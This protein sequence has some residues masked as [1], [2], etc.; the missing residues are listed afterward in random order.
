MQFESLL[1]PISEAQPCGEDISYLPE[2]MELD[3]MIQGTPETQF[4]EAVKP[5]WKLIHLRC[6]E[7]FQK[8]KHLQVSAVFCVSSLQTGGIPVAAGALELL[9]NLLQK[10]W[11]DLY[12]KLD[13]EDDNDPLERMNILSSLS[14]PIGTFGDYFQ[15]IERLREA[16]LTNSPVLGRIGYGT[17]MPESGAHGGEAPDQTQIDAAFRDTPQ[18]DIVSTHEALELGHL[19]LPAWLPKILEDAFEP[20]TATQF[21][22]PRWKPQASG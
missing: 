14:A 11:D 1:E 10:Y 3:S 7:L 19:A 6:L 12:P 8:S 22:A 5:D 15:F 21:R 18:E 17:L 9:N 2:F 4:S 16:P 20:A 13:P